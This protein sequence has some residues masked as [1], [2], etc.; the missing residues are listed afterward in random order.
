MLNVILIDVVDKKVGPILLSLNHWA[1]W[2][3]E[4][5]T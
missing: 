5:Q 4:S 2:V 1:H 3:V